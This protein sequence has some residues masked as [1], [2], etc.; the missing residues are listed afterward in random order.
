MLLNYAVLSKFKNDIKFV[1][2]FLRY[3]LHRSHDVRHLKSA[4]PFCLRKLL[5]CVCKFE[6]RVYDFTCGRDK[7]CFSLIFSFFSKLKHTYITN[8]FIFIYIHLAHFSKLLTKLSFF[9]LG[10]AQKTLNI[11]THILIGFIFVLLLQKKNSS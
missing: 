3:L 8:L 1:K 7:S 4:S 10:K 5:N 6:T 2:L 11:T 9:P